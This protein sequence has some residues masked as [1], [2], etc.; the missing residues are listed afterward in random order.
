MYLGYK[1]HIGKVRNVNQDAFLILDNAYE[2]LKIFAVADGLGGHNA[3]EV[4]SNVLINNIRKYF[5]N[6][7]LLVDDTVQRD[8]ITEIIKEINREIYEQGQNDTH[9]SGMGT[10]LTMTLFHNDSLHLFHVG[11]SRAYI[12]NN[13]EILQLTKDHSL[14]EQ[15]VMQGEITREEARVH[16]QKNILTRAIGT[17][18]NTEIDYYTY[19]VNKDD[20]ILLCTDGLTNLVGTDEIK[21][22]INKNTC[23]EACNVLI[24]RANELGGND[25]ITVIIFHPEVKL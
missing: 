5:L 22:I 16:P 17:D 21:D 25:N 15:L 4:A 6:E 13:R 11:D 18:I 8:K 1:S 24:E 3:G 19:S 7:N 9:L 20:K 10:T 12:I 2:D 23:S 14:V